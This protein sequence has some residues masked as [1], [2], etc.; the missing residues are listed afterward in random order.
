MLFCERV[1]NFRTI[2]YPFFV[3]RKNILSSSSSHSSLSVMLSTS[4]QRPTNSSI[5]SHESRSEVGVISTLLFLVP[6][7]S[8]IQ[9]RWYLIFHSLILRWLFIQLLSSSHSGVWKSE[10]INQQESLTGSLSQVCVSM[11]TLSLK[12]SSIS[13]PIVSSAWSVQVS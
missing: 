2:S 7:L 6:M 9:I 12:K 3:W 11:A 10:L 13:T 4:A 5:Q 1:Y 8:C